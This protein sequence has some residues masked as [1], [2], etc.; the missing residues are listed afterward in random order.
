MIVHPFLLVD[1]ATRRDC[2]GVPET[3]NGLGFVGIGIWPSDVG[4]YLAVSGRGRSL[5]ILLAFEEDAVELIIA[6]IA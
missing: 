5:A 6:G 3:G 4:E 1:N 2:R